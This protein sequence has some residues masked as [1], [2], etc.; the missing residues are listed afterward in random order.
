MKISMYQASV[1]RLANV[2]EN[3]SNILDKAQAHV[4]AGHADVATLMNYRLAPDMYPFFKQVQI[5]CDKARSVVA[6]L[7]G[8]EVPHYPD[9][10]KTF[11]EL[12]ERIARTVAFLRS[13]PPERIDG[14]EDDE[15]VLP[16]TGKETRYKGMQLLL[17]HSMPNVYFHAVTAYNILRQNGVPIGKRDFLGNP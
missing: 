8:M 9:D 10:E 13:V 16:V 1:P 11:A 2:L 5:A 4:D 6:R 12:K 15:I 7:T 17:G 14:T 3:L